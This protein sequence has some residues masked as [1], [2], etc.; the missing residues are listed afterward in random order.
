MSLIDLISYFFFFIFGTNLLR[1]IVLVF[2][3][4]SF[5][6]SLVDLLV[7]HVFFSY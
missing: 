5:D 2:L 6:Y 7:F 3:L 4:K 1:V